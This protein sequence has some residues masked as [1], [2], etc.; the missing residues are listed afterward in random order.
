MPFSGVVYIERDD[1]REQDSKD[2][3]GLAPGKSVMLR[4]VNRHARRLSC[5]LIRILHRMNLATRLSM[6]SDGLAPAKSVMP[7][8]ACPHPPALLHCLPF[9]E[10]STLG[11]A[12]CPR[13]AQYT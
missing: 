12:C 11:D 9:R 4:C 1:F 6:D 13:R 2:F 3:F 10:G 5:P 7:R 8:S